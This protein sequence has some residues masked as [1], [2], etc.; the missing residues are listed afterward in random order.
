MLACVCQTE[1]YL[2]TVGAEADPCYTRTLAAAAGH[3][4]ADVVERARSMGLA[5]CFEWK[6]TGL[7][8]LRLCG[9]D[10]CG[11]PDAGPSREEE[12]QRAPPAVRAV[13]PPKPRRGDGASSGMAR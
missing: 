6:G 3:V 13:C 2:L 9:S 1:S 10:V 8:G 7:S 4:V 12:A 11:F 5:A